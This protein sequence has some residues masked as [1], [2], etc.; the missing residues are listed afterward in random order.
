MGTSIIAI[1]DALSEVIFVPW[2]TRTNNRE[3]LMHADKNV[4]R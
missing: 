1:F 2:E 4:Q 3:P